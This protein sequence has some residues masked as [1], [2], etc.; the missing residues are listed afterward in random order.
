MMEKII[1]LGIFFLTL[2][3]VIKK[4]KGID[5]GWSATFGSF[6]AFIF[7]VVSVNDIFKV[8][9]IV[10]DPTLAFIGIIFISLIL[11]K[12]GFFEWAALHIIKFSKGDGKKL[13]IYLILLGSVISA[14][15]ANDGSALILTPIVYQKIKH[16]GLNQKYM[17]P[18]IM[19]SGFVSD[20]TSLPL[21]ISNL[22][23]ILTAD[24]FKIGFFEYAS[25]MIWVNLFSLFATVI[26]LYL[27]FKKDLLKKVDLEA[28]EDKP[29]K[30][31]IKDRFLFKLSWFVFFILF[32][33]FFVAEHFNIPV[34]FV[35]GLGA[36]ILGIA[37]YKEEIVD[38][39]KLVLI[40]T[41]WKII[42]F[43]IGMYVVVYG[44]KNAGFSEVLAFIIK[45]SVDTSLNTGVLI[46]GF[47]A[48]ILS[49][50]MNNLPSVMIVNLSILDTGLDIQTMKILAYAN[51]IGCDL[52]P[53]IT[54]I[55]FSCNTFMASV[56]DQKGIHI[57]WRYYFKV[58]VVLT[59]PTLFFTLLGL[60]IVNNLVK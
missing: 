7:G 46:T 51:I 32:L 4:P 42:V 40:E 41:P 50:I 11:D 36:L 59:L 24:F 39:K 10:W 38:M 47:L 54:P 45:E 30:Y 27:Y 12:I 14:F 31:A 33:G 5:I 16:L 49:S 22:V 3:L 28:I 52:G 9:E 6:L 25:V 35:I 17:L 20:T 58:G 18:Y 34:S 8:V 1:S 2:Y 53:K 13:F 21:I 15:F 19:G 37:T 48:A 44:L 43:S 23:N 56:L 57:S 29:P 26:V 55:A 60:I